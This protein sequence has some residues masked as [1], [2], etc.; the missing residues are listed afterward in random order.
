MRCSICKNEIEL[1]Q[2]F[3]ITK[4]NQTICDNC[5]ETIEVYAIQ[6]ENNT[7]LSCDELIFIGNTQ[8]YNDKINEHYD[9]KKSLENEISDLYKIIKM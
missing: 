9:S 1:K 4:Q 8:A 2:E 5:F 6:D 7:T 3:I